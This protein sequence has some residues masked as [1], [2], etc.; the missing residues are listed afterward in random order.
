MCAKT[1]KAGI[2]KS[3]LKLLPLLLLFACAKEQPKVKPAIYHWKTDVTLNASD[4]LKLDSLGIKRMYVHYFDIDKDEDKLK[5]LAVVNWKSLPPAHLEIVPTVFITNR[6]M[7]FL[8]DTAAESLALHVFTKIEKINLQ[9]GRSVPEIQM[10]CDWTVETGPTYFRFLRALKVLCESKNWVLS[11]TIRLHQ[12]KFPEKTGVPPVDR[13]MLMYYNMGD[14]GDVN[15]TNSILN[16]EKAALY[17]DK[18]ADYPLELDLAV[19]LFS[20]V[21]HFRSSEFKKLLKT[22]NRDE[23]DRDTLF[24]KESPNWYVAKENG[25]FKGEYILKNDRFR[26]EEILPEMNMEI[27]NHLSSRWKHPPVN[28]SL[29]YYNP[30]EL[31]NYACYRIKEVYSPPTQ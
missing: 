12:I 9:L 6:A 15:E 1:D 17:T 5:P 29:F 31:E 30:Y 13:G 8:P 25:I 3:W 20:W 28:L 18:L 23:L 7:K 21:I 11:A 4:S 19:P 16:L 24:R 26:V 27:I 10:D 14:L 2:L 22:W